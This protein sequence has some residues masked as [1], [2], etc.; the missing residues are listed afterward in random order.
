MYL[1]D[2]TVLVR[3]NGLSDK[4]DR[5]MVCILAKRSRAI[6]PMA[7]QNED[8]ACDWQIVNLSIC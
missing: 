1:F 5:G 3:F 8:T 6:I 4:S 7:R 2:R